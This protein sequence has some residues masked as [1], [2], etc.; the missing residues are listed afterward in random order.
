MGKNKL[1]IEACTIYRRV[2][3]KKWKN[4]TIAFFMS[5]PSIRMM[6]NSSTGFHDI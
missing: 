1:L 2:R 4:V 6:A 5:V 3:K